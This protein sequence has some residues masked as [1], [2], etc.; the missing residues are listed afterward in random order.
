[1]LSEKTGTN[2][3]GRTGFVA[4]LLLLV[5]S[6]IGVGITDYS[7]AGAHHYWVFMVLA[8]A[9]ISMLGG[10]TRSRNAGEHRSVSWV[11]V[12]LLHWSACVAAV[13]IVYSLVHAGRIN[14]ADAGLIL[15]L[16]LAL[17]VFLNGA[18]AGPYF[19]LLGIVLGGMTITMAYI[20]RFIWFILVIAVIGLGVAIYWE[21][22]RAGKHEHAG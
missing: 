11:T 6:V 2:R 18:H 21:R 19:Y 22:L 12:Q 3:P 15:L 7:P 13:L 4:F 14:N 1:M 5:L 16:L 8:S 9:F 10:L 17:A 20:E